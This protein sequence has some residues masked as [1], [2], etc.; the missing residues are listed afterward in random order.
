MTNISKGR[1]SGGLAIMWR[2]HLT[3]YVTNIKSDLYRVQAVKF[4]FPSADLLIVNLYLMVDPQVDQFDEIGLLNLLAEVNRIIQSSD[5][6][7]ILLAGDLNCDF[8]RDTLF[9]NT[10]RQFVNDNNLCIFWSL[11]DESE[12]HRIEEVKATY[13]SSVNGVEY[14]SCIDHFLGNQR[15]YNVVSEAGVIN[16][17]DNHSGHSPIYTRMNVDQL[18]LEV[19]VP[20]KIPKHSWE[21]A[22]DEEKENFRGTLQQLLENLNP[23]IECADCD[24]LK[25][26]EHDVTVD[27]YATGICE[28]LDQAVST[29]LP[30]VGQS[31]RQGGQ[32]VI[33]GWT[34]YV[35]P[36][37]DESLF[38]NGVW[39][40]AGCPEVGELYEINRQAK[41]QYKYAVRRL[42]RAAYNIK[43]DKLLTGLLDGGLDIFQEIKKFRGKTSTVSSSVDGYIG[44]EDI[45]NHFADIYSELYQKHDLGE[46][47][48]RVQ[49]SIVLQVDP[50]LLGELDRVNEKTVFEALTKLKSGKSDPTFSFN[51]DCLLNSCDD[52]IKHVTI[53]F[54][55]FLRTGTIPA[56][57]L[58]CTI[59]PIVKDNLGDIASSDNYRAIAI[60]SLLLKW[61][62]WLIIILEGD[63]LATDELQFGFQAK[64]STSMCTWAINTVIDHYNR[65]DRPIFAC[66]MDLSKAF[67]MVSWAKLFPELLKRKISPLILR[68]LIHIYSNQMCN[69]RW[70]NIIS[71][72]FN[73]KNGV[74]QG[75][76]SS[77]ILFC[78]YI[79]DLIVQLRN[80]KVGCQLNCVYLGIWVYA[81]DIILLSPSRSGLQLMT[82]V[83]EKFASLHQLNFSTN[84]DVSKSK[85]KC[86]VFSNPVMNTD[87]ICP[88]LL[89][90][91]PLPYVTEIKH[92]GNTLQSNGSMSKDVSCKRAKFISKIHSLN[93]EFHYAN[94]S[95]VLKLYDIYTC[96]FYG[97]NLWDLY[98]RDVQKLLNS[99][100]IAIRILFDLPRETHRY[101]I[102]P[103]SN[104]PHIKTVLCTRF[105]Q[106]VTSLS[107]CHKLC[108][109]LLVDLS[110]H[111]LRTVLCKNLESIA[112]DCNVQSRNLNKFCVKQNMIYNHIPLDQEWK[113]PILHELL[114]VKEDNFVLN[115]FVDIEIATMINFLCSD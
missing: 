114:K 54:K 24:S 109:R 93:Q 85:T 103:I 68:C 46:E 39:R 23:P 69:V 77:P 6:R 111:D 112:Q 53:L 5:C 83:C 41:M 13:S 67:D 106:F 59:V 36:Y 12:S 18:N 89:N 74:R 75:A 100:N 33:P 66:S 97:S 37:Q 95:T 84:V 113:L 26:V 73:V 58:L 82:N 71:Q 34:E 25:C 4:N 48:A 40:A 45:S 38:W 51:S 16:S 76:V 14:F 92:L 99:W 35:K 72:P 28:A 10:V 107:N 27:T 15:L 105:V 29:C 86:I 63:K 22:S 108:I 2:K 91:L 55:W 1:G 94:T 80:L 50:S 101:F 87:N 79:N 64:S 57:L 21:N 52:L 8:K 110:K 9:V 78:V 11:P 65:L 49:E 17:P 20:E 115:N 56:F 81:D 90:N 30:L 88:I 43:K 32:K 96:D 19:E 60:G 104:V 98:S 3:K 31:L 44:A 47:F 42:K 70:G 61:F 7:N 102:E 62:D